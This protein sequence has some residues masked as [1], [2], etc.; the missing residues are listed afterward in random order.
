MSKWRLALLLV[1]LCAVQSQIGTAQTRQYYRYL[2]ESNVVVIDD[3]IPP[4]YSSK[5]YDIID[6][7]GQLIQRVAPAI[8][9]AEKA[10]RDS[11]LVQQQFD[12]DLLRRYSSEADIR[13]AER[14]F[15]NE[16]ALRLNAL[17]AAVESYLKGIEDTE[18]AISKE[19]DQDKLDGLNRHLSLLKREMVQT[20]ASILERKRER[21]NSAEVF[22]KELSRLKELKAA[23]DN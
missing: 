22:A 9:G 17:E 12:R 15:N 16:V 13:S 21:E 5:G 6:S 18:N 4:K 23:A 8:T 1:A 11:E 7:Y 2:N 10:K 14:R 20:Q 3:N 19:K